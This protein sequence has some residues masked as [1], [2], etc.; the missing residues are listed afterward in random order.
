MYLFGRISTRF[1]RKK[2]VLILSFDILA[3]WT[4]TLLELQSRL[5]GQTT[6]NPSKSVPNGSQDETAVLKGFRDR[7]I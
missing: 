5:G 3:T 1:F 2:K 4:L 6:P 7:S